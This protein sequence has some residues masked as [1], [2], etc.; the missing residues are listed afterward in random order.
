MK[1]TITQEEEDAIIELDNEGFKY[2]TAMHPHEYHKLRRLR[3]NTIRRREKE[4]AF[5]D[6]QDADEQAMRDGGKSLENKKKKK[7]EMEKALNVA[8]SM[9]Y[10]SYIQGY[11]KGK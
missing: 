7:I 1:K 10:I 3:E 5:L 6:Q 9:D 2:E 4:L 11:D 8:N